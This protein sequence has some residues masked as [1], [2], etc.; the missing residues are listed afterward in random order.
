MPDN[1]AFKLYKSNKLESFLPEVYPIIEKL[2]KASPLKK[3]SIVVQSDGMARWLTVNVTR[4]NGVFANFDFV[5]PDGFL[6]NFAE[7]YFGI[8]ADSVYNKKNAEWEL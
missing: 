3:K 1:F 6:R 2:A 5:S 7:K 8:T 4:E